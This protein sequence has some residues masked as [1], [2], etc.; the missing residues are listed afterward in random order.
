MTVEE[1][2]GGALQDQYNNNVGQGA[3]LVWLSLTTYITF[4]MQAG[5]AFL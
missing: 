1:L 2:I 3:V 4:V 5:F